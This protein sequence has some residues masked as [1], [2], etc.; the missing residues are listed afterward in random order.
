[1]NFHITAAVKDY[2]NVGNYI[3]SNTVVMKEFSGLCKSNQQTLFFA[4]VAGNVGNNNL[5]EK[6]RYEETEHT[7]Y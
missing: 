2:S 5:L 4:S 1:M 7:I 6:K 3:V